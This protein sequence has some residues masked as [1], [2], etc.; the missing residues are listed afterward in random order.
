MLYPIMYCVLWNGIVT[1]I[2]VTKPIAWVKTGPRCCWHAQFFFFFFC[3]VGVGEGDWAFNRRNWCSIYTT[4]YFRKK[5][6]EGHI[7]FLTSTIICDIRQW[8]LSHCVLHLIALC[9]SIFMKTCLHGVA[10]LNVTVGRCIMA[11]VRKIKLCYPIDKF[12]CK[13]YHCVNYIFFRSL[14]CPYI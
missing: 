8:E 1:I 12:Y 5:I 11:T 10:K 4:F 9:S 3:G 6:I 2:K 7:E 14:S 13:C